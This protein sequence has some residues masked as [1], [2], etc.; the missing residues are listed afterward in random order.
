M[1]N[2]GGV[3]FHLPQE[4][5]T[6]TRRRIPAG[7]GPFTG[8]QAAGNP[9]RQPVRGRETRPVIAAFH[10]GKGGVGTTTLAVEC[11][12]AIC[13]TGASVGLIDLDLYAGDA[14][15]RLDTDCARGG[16]TLSDLLPVIDELDERM[17]D[18]AFS[19]CPSGVR[20]LPA[21][22]DPDDA[23]RVGPGQLSTLLQ[24]A[25]A[26]FDILVL[27]TAPRADSSA[28]AALKAC[29]LAV[30]VTSP[31]VSC[32][33]RIRS[34]SDKLG[35]G[36]QAGRRPALIIN[37]SLGRSDLVTTREAERF[38]GMPAFAV[39]P[40]ATYAFRRAA[41]EGRLICGERSRPGRSISE[42]AALVLAALSSPR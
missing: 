30:L 19:R 28:S 15:Y 26:A 31:E 1:L 7:R 38:L 21:P 35:Q 10:G 41:D 39:I 23:S 40:E 18:N 22:S 9:N 32:L 11:A 5:G 20:V 42:V 13:G 2:R 33:G 3:S 14:H 8:R 29:D 12:A 25:G 36:D 4:S 34:V 16:Y 17:I 24:I 6:D 37:R 27:D